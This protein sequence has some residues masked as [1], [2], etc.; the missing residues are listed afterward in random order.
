M[1]QVLSHPCIH[2]PISIAEMVSAD[3]LNF[4]CLE[5]IVSYLAGRDLYSVTHVSRSFLAAALPLLY[6][7]L[8][9]HLGNGK[10]YPKVRLQLPYYL[11]ALTVSRNRQVMTA[12]DT[13]KLHP[14]LAVHVHHIGKAVVIFSGI[15]NN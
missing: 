13:V 6:R 14:R 15:T 9:F 11:S 2:V 8:T 3:N 10:R 5:L 1:G 12:F 7:S 4:D